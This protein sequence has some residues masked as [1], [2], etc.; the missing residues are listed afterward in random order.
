MTTIKNTDKLPESVILLNLSGNRKTNSSNR[1]ARKII[2]AS[3]FKEA[4]ESSTLLEGKI[5]NT[6][7]IKMNAEAGINIM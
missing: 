5:S 4:S 1:G 7:K 3:E 6:C 2:N